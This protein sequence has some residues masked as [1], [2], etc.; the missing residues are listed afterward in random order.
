MKTVIDIG[1]CYEKLVKGFIVNIIVECNVESNR[2][3]RMVYDRG[4]CVKL[5]P[6]IIN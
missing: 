6:S 2:E 4:K 5:S 1:I 3:Y